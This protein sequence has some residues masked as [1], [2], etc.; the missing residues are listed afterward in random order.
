MLSVE[1]N[2]KSLNFVSDL[3]YMLSCVEE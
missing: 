3:V 2:V 1:N